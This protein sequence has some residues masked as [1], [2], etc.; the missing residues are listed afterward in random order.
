MWPVDGPVALVPLW[1][2]LQFVMPVW[3]TFAGVHA[4][5]EWQLLHSDVVGKCEVGLPA[6]FTPS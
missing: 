1:Q 4:S 2:P 3:S 6:A 5:D